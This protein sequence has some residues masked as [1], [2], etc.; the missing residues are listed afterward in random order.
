MKTNKLRWPE[1]VRAQPHVSERILLYLTVLQNAQHYFVNHFIAK[2]PETQFSH[3]NRAR[4]VHVKVMLD[5]SQG[6]SHF[7]FYKCY[8]KNKYS[9]KTVFWEMSM[10]SVKQES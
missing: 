6:E 7:V 9:Q 3:N 1:K 5:F 8:G 2:Y 4:K 10:Y